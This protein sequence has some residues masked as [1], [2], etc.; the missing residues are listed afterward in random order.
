MRGR[1]GIV[2]A[3]AMVAI[4]LL[5]GCARHRDLVATGLVVVEP[6]ID[7]NLRNPPDVY[8]DQG[9]LVVYGTVQMRSPGSL[10]GHVDVSV[11]G[12]DGGRLHEAQVAYRPKTTST[13][14]WAGRRPS[15]F[16]RAHRRNASF[17]VYAVRFS[18]L[19]PAG[20]VVKVRHDPSPLP[21]SMPAHCQGK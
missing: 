13:S 14:G 21:A 4:T 6:R 20:S 1:T 10:G 15:V 11:I 12:P 9:D 2:V 3:L 5:A 16:H 18:G 17:G 7:R 8:E 19:P